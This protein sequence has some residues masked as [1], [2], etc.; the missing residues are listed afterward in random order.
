M[1]APEAA[2]AGGKSADGT[3]RSAE[4]ICE[5]SRN[6]IVLSKLRDINDYFSLISAMAAFPVSI[7]RV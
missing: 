2:D 3:K 6:S 7:H 4:Q 1:A 5:A